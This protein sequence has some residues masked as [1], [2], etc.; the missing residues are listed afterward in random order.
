MAKRGEVVD[1]EYDTLLFSKPWGHKIAFKVGHEVF[2][3][4]KISEL[5]EE[6]S[7]VT[8]PTWFAEKEGLEDY[9]I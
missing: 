8:V 9:A 4:E 5:D 3:P 7:I 1:L 6:K 2:V